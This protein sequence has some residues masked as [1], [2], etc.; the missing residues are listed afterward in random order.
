[1]IDDYDLIVASFQTQYGLRLSKE[2]HNMP[3]T[4]FCQLLSGIMPDTPLGKIVSIRTED[5]KEILKHFTPDQKRIRTE[6]MSKQAK[7]KTL[8]ETMAFV[9]EM[10]QAFI[11]MS[12]GGGKN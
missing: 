8:D 3:W 7:A 11:R 1:M 10:K 5:D 2:I 6:W 9:E 4:E 12:G